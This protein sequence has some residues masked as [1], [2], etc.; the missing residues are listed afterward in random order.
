MLIGEMGSVEGGAGD[1]D[2]RRGVSPVGGSVREGARA[3]WTRLDL[4]LVPSLDAVQNEALSFLLPGL[5]GAV[6]DS[7]RTK[8]TA[9]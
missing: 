1:I 7:P 2:R 6:G 8:A 4:P 3:F 9:L 5:D